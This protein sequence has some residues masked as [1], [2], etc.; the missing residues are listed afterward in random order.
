MSEPSHSPPITNVMLV[1]SPSRSEIGDLLELG[2]EVKA[3]GG[4]G[5]VAPVLNHWLLDLLGVSPGLG[6]DFLGDID[7]LLDFL[8]K[9]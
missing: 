8:K 2:G 5:G 1:T 3:S 6:A 4:A 9:K 7:T